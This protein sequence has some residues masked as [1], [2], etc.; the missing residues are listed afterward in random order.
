M[1][2]IKF[3]N[4]IIDFTIPT[5]DTMVEEWWDNLTEKCR[6]MRMDDMQSKIRI[7]AEVAMFFGAFAYLAAAVRE[8]KFLGMRMFYEN[9]VR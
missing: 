1:L 8:A 5:E 7:A 2:P 3:L 6:L 4:I 9:L